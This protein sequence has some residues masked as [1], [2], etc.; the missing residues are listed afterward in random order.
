MMS[1][2]DLLATDFVGEG[3]QLIRL[4]RPAQHNAL[5]AELLRQIADVLAKAEGDPEIRCVVVTGNERAFSA[6]ADIKEM[7][8]DGFEAIDN[9]ARR[10]SWRTIERFRKPLIAAVRGICLGGGFEFAML[11]DIVI[12]ADNAVFGQ[13]E[14]TIGILP[15][16]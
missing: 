8:K 15:G 9:H 14:I 1:S 10:S 6:G 4:N 7:Q 2:Y 3:V 13:P 11:A 16:D 5:S 12:T